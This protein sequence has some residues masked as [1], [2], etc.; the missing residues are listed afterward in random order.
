MI[1]LSPE[2]IAG[3]TGRKRASAQARVLAAMSISFRLRPDG[4]ILVLEESVRKA[5][6]WKG[7]S[8]T[9]PAWEPDFSRV[10]NRHKRGL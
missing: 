7:E 3:I 5:V 1:V 6:T 8:L 4:S 9:A 2:E 10:F